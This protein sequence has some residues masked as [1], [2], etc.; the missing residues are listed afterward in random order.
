MKIGI[1]DADLLDKGTR[2]PNLAL[3]KISGYHKSLN[4]EVKLISSYKDI[5]QYD[6]IYMSK[7]FTFTK[8]PPEI[9]TLPNMEIGGTGFFEDGGK[10]LPIEIEHHMPDY[11]L[12][13]EFVEGKIAEGHN[14]IRYSDY[15]DYSIGFTTRG[16][17]RKCKFCVNKKYD[18]AFKHSPVSEFIDENKPYIYLWDDNFLAFNGWEE[19]LDELEATKKPFQFRQG[20]D[21]RLLDDKKANRLSQTH[22][23][24]DFIFAFDH[25]EERGIIERKLKL[26]R[27]YSNKTTK[28]YL[29][30]AYD[31]QDIEDIIHTFERIKILMSYGCL[32]YIMRYDDYKTSKFRTLYTELARWCNQPQ[33]FKKKSFRQFCEANQ[34]VHKNSE[35]TCSAYQC[36]LDFE[37]AY[38]EIAKKYFD[39]RFDQENQYSIAYGFGRKY[40]HKSDCVTCAHDQNTWLNAY[41]EKTTRSDLLCQ[42]F[43]R[44]MDLQ[45]LN[46]QESTCKLEI[47]SSK[48]ANWFIN[49][50]LDATWDEIFNAL[51]NRIN[52][53]KINKSNISQFSNI[54][55][56]IEKV[57]YH[58]YSGEVDLSYEEMGYQL[59][60]KQKNTVARRKYGENHAKFAA[61][62]DLVTITKIDS[63]YQIRP[64]V[65]GTSYYKLDRD[66]QA[67]LAAK[68]MFRIPIVQEMFID[69]QEGII[70]IEDYL[71]DLSQT[72][73]IRRR[74]NIRD[75]V[76]YI[77]KYSGDSHI[78]EL[79]QKILDYKK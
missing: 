8:V 19:I 37:A 62:L 23:H 63:N 18:R 79:C 78:N 55:Y 6:Q 38:P 34:K 47:E 61:Q 29:L 25:I 36:M 59:D 28:L 71:K 67:I 50:L 56:A 52:P 26:W 2:H 14:R 57:P 45:C 35:T 30:C 16:C 32:P 42:Y 64:S 66:K 77:K 68:L 24:G 72:T 60:G 22:Y 11:T 10:D 20:L 4:D 40:A 13:Q 1:I 74:S 12:Y 75:I 48:I 54:L 69:A 58:I 33:F 5:G 73:L 65:F 41:L 39:L 21:I 3:M 44:E 9:L 76:E 46:Y 17:F 70:Y 15:L 31:S 27:R 51:Q 7:V 53:E 43:S 49:I